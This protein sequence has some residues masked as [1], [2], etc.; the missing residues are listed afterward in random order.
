MT[1]IAPSPEKPPPLHT[2]YVDGWACDPCRAALTAS[3]L[4]QNPGAR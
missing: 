1:H 2:C 3:Y 4:A